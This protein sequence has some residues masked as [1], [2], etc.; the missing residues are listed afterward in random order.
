[1][2]KNLRI[3]ASLDKPDFL[4]DL[5]ERLAER[6]I[7]SGY[8]KAKVPRGQKAMEVSSNEAY[9]SGDVSLSYMNENNEKEM[10]NMPFITAFLFTCTKSGSAKKT[11]FKLKWSASLS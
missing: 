2:K 5:V 9:V 1:M 10:I 8:G 7:E 3:S 11:A 4:E 6:R